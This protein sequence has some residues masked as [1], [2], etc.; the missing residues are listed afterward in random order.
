MLTIS[1]HAD[2]RRIAPGETQFE[3]VLGALSTEI[4]E[5]AVYF[6]TVRGIAGRKAQVAALDPEALE[7]FIQHL[8]GLRALL[9]PSATPQEGLQSFLTSGDTCRGEPCLKPST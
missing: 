7:A 9:A 3:S 5:G 1:T 4:R 2:S 6:T 8:Q